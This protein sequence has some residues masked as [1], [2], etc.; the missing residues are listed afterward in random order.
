MAQSEPDRL[1]EDDLLKG[2]DETA[3]SRG[4]LGGFFAVTIAASLFAW[5]TMFDLGAYHVVFY[6]TR[7]QLFVLSLVVLLGGLA[8]RRRAHIN[9]WLLALFSPPLVLVLLQLVFPV[10][11]SGAAIRVIAHVLVVATVAVSPFVLW[12]VARL[13]APNYFT[14]PDRKTKLVVIGIVAVV[15]L[16]GFAVGRLDDHFLT[17]E[18]FQVAGDDT[19]SN[20]VHIHRR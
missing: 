4:K 12:V 15:A 18:D 17:C 19:P 3:P 16:I 10:N 11:H 7:H 1:S 13:L 9:P 5:N 2:F 8:M 14:L 20:C 6:R